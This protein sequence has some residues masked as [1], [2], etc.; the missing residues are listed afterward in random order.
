MILPQQH[1]TD[2]DSVTST[3]T[4]ATSF[5]S[6]S[7]NYSPIGRNGKNSGFADLPPIQGTKICSMSYTKLKVFSMPTRWQNSYTT[8]IVTLWHFFAPEDRDPFQTSGYP[9]YFPSKQCIQ[10]C[11]RTSQNAMNQL[12]FHV[13]ISKSQ[14]FTRFYYFKPIT[15]QHFI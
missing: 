12:D 4:Y 11:T 13:R 3:F 10:K 15:D 1:N 2:H 5:R 8:I 6:Q 9:H 14:F 7:T